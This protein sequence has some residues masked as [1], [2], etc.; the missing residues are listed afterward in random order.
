MLGCIISAHSSLLFWM[1]A[2]ES[3]LLL[4]LKLLE[5]G[6]GKILNLLPP[7]LV[8]S[9]WD[10]SS[11]SSGNRILEVGLGWVRTSPPGHSS[12][13]V[14][15]SSLWVTSASGTE[16]V[17]RSSL[18][19]VASWSSISHLDSPTSADTKWIYSLG[20]RLVLLSPVTMKWD[21]RLEPH[22]VRQSLG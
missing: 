14:S 12:L 2:E 6:W 5:F 9:S 22:R 16:S 19:W 21:S 15:R 3:W 10:P 8:F 18:S 17:H 11:W 7:R 13:R 1:F 20:N 4:E